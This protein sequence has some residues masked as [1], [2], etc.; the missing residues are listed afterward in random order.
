MDD[1]EE[2]IYRIGTH[3]IDKLVL[4]FGVQYNECE[5]EKVV[6]SYFFNFICCWISAR[7]DTPSTMLSQ[8][9]TT[10]TMFRMGYV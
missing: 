7:L 6:R 3:F 4:A 5:T 8:D 2:T 9:T 1:W 10:E